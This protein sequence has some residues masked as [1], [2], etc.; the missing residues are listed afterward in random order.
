MTREG[1]LERAGS[2]TRR[3]LLRVAGA[4]AV[5][6]GTNLGVSQS[7]A[8]ALSRRPGRRVAVLGGGMSG[9]TAA[10]EL[11][12]R[13]F[14]VTVYERKSLGGKSRSIPVP[15]T[16]QGGRRALPGEHGFRFFPGFYHHVP[17]TMR[18]IPFPGNANGVWDNLVGAAETR[19][20]R[21]GSADATVP[22]RVDPVMLDPE[23]LRQT[24]IAALNLGTRV[25]PHR[26]RGVRPAVLDFP[27]QLRRAAV[28]A[29][30][31]RVVV[32]LRAGRGQV[33]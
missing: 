27:H 31:V 19:L 21:T 9:L 15:G 6:A 1:R 17:D 29:V 23:T 20:S 7:P 32:G 24:L 18:R 3:G 10:H 8:A 13:G 25:P 11:A 2:F 5:V 33:G 28:R 12:E 26:A 22:G 16:G 30:G 4:A 14:E